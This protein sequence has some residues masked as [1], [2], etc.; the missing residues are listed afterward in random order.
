MLLMPFSGTYLFQVGLLSVLFHEFR[1][2]ILFMFLYAALYA[3]YVTV[4]VVRRLARGAS[5]RERARLALTPLHP[6]PRRT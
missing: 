6:P 2:P 4:K 3:I 1:A 5:A